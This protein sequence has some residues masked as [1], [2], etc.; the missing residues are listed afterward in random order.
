LVLSPFYVVFS[1]RD[2]IDF[3]VLR[4]AVWAFQSIGFSHDYRLL[5]LEEQNEKRG[6]LVREW[7]HCHC[8]RLGLKLHI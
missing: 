8:I 3:Q 1:K 6:S 4:P 7:I 2:S 5:L